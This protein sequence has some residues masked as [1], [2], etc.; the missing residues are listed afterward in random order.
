MAEPLAQPPLRLPRAPS[1]Q[2]HESVITGLHSFRPGSSSGGYYQQQWGM[3]LTISGAA[4][5]RFDSSGSETRHGDLLLGPPPTRSYWQV[6]GEEPWE[7][8]YA[9]FQPRPHW[10]EWLRQFNIVDGRTVVH[11]EDEELFTLVRDGMTRAHHLNLHSSTNRQDWALL[12]LEE[13]FLHL[14]AHLARERETTDPRVDEAIRYMHAHFP[15]P[16]SMAVLAQV[17]YLSESRLSLLFSHQVGKSPMEYL[18][19]VR[20]TRACDMLRFGP[21]PIAEIASAVG[22]HD[23][24]YFSRRFS[25]FTKLSPRAYRRNPLAGEKR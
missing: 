13:V 22:Y 12:A 21:A 18:E 8:V 25:Q 5:W 10:H 7:T 17:V 6:V 24:N 15:E 20:L 1:G 3:N 2:G 11:L 14:H 9:A 16:I 23:A 19:S 4:Y